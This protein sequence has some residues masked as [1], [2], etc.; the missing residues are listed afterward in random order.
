MVANTCLTELSKTPN[1]LLNL[2][3][4]LSNICNKS[5][6]T[7]ELSLY[8]K[9]REL[10]KPKQDYKAGQMQRSTDHRVPTPMNKS[11]S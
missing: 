11:V 3:L 8:S 2:I 4:I 10:Q 6:L 7:K 1:K 9:C 5:H